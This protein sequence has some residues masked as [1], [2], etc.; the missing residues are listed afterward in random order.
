MHFDTKSYLKNNRYHTAKHALY[1]L[2]LILSPPIFIVFKDEY[3]LF[4]NYFFIFLYFIF[5]IL[6]H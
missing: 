1:Q 4:K 6:I 3:F 5:L 2:K